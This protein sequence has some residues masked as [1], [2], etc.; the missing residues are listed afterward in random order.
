[1]SVK[2]VETDHSKTSQV[3]ECILT[4]KILN[5]LTS[6]LRLTIVDG[7]LN[8]ALTSRK[9]SN[10]IFLDTDQK[11]I[12]SVINSQRSL[13][14]PFQELIK[15]QI[16]D[17]IVKLYIKKFYETI[18]FLLKSGQAIIG[19]RAIDRAMVMGANNHFP[20][21]ILKTPEGSVSIC[22][23]FKFKRRNLKLIT[24]PSDQMLKDITAKDKISYCCIMDS[25][26]GVHFA[27]DFLKYLKF[28]GQ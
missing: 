12:K 13:P 4:G 22:N 20:Y 1:M 7:V 9:I 28:T 25:H 5:E 8:I 14:S 18:G 6:P 16:Y 10:A 17:D 27:N 21:A 11:L 24:L 3:S 23:S 2:V 15:P 19:R 26:M